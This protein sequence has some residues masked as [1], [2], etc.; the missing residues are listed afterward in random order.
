MKTNYTCNCNFLLYSCI[1]LCVNVSVGM[2]GVGGGAGG[3]ST[4]EP[5]LT[6]LIWLPAIDSS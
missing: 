4:P 3:G 6:R 5:G 2:R 1:A